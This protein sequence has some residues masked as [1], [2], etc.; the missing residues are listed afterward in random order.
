MPNG[1]RNLALFRQACRGESLGT[2]VARLR[3]LAESTGTNGG[4]RGFEGIQ[5]PKKN[6]KLLILEART[7][8]NPTLSATSFCREFQRLSSGAMFPVANPVANLAT[9]SI[10]K[11]DSRLRF[12]LLA[13]FLAFMAERIN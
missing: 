4:R 11:W 6:S 12:G 8:S 13:D 2:R 7:C 3:L 5:S 9:G 10:R 1:K